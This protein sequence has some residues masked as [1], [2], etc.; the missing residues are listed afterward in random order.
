MDDLSVLADGVP[1][2]GLGG[3]R[4]DRYTAGRLDKQRDV[5]REVPM[6]VFLKSLPVTVEGDVPSRHLCSRLRGGSNVPAPG[7]GR[8]QVFRLGRSPAR[9][10]ARKSR[11]TATVC[12]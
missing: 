9:C 1:V 8:C 6:W 12:C 7:S 11:K 2:C 5:R 10:T 3:V 4:L